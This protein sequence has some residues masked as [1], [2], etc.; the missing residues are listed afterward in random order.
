MFFFVTFLFLQ[1]L[2]KY[3]ER[4][5]C[6]WCM[7]HCQQQC[8]LYTVRTVRMYV[9]WGW[10]R[11]GKQMHT[12]AFVGGMTRSLCSLTTYTLCGHM[13]RSLAS[14]PSVLQHLRMHVC[15]FVQYVHV[16][17]DMHTCEL[18]VHT[19]VCVYVYVCSPCCDKGLSLM[20]RLFNRR[21]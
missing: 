1:F 16:R 15:V 12:L 9:C 21:G 13:Q 17:T 8:L 14:K 2:I 4:Y 5:V 20:V 3:H 19:Y 7:V 10:A 6:M 18:S 11:L